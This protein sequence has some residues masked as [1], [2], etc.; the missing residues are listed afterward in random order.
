MNSPIF[1][2]LALALTGALTA[3]MPVGGG[4]P[5]AQ[6]GGNLTVD[7]LPPGADPDDPNY[8]IADDPSQLG[9]GTFSADGLEN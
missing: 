8:R 7:E 6:T 2:A 9:D 4:A 1:T 3:C 5:P